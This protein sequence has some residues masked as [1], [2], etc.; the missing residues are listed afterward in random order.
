[1]RNQPRRAGD[2]LRFALAGPAVTAVLARVFAA[3]LQALPSSA[4]LA[5][6]SG[7]GQATCGWPRY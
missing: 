6:S 5:R 3:V 1:M 7:S 2:E 4:P